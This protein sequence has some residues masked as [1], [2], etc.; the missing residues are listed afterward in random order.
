MFARVRIPVPA[1]PPMIN[2]EPLIDPDIV[3]VVVLI[4]LL[5]STATGVSLVLIPATVER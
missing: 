5:V 2:T 3:P 1:A 4:T